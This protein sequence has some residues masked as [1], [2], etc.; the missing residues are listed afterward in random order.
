MKNCTTC[1][2]YGC[3]YDDNTSYCSAPA[4][5]VENV[6]GLNILDSDKGLDVFCTAP[7]FPL[8]EPKTEA[9]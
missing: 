1:K 6:F 8:H 5:K 9:A 7:S 4:V 3:D 2:Y